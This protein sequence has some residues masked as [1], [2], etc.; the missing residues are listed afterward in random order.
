MLYAVRLGPP[1]VARAVVVEGPLDVLA[2]AAAAATTGLPMLSCSTAGVTVSEAQAQTVSTLTRRQVVLA[3][4]GDA[5]GRDGTIRWVELLQRR[6][7]HPVAV[8]DLPDGRDP[9]DVL[10]Q[11]GPTALLDLLARARPSAY[12]LAG[13]TRHA[14]RPVRPAHHVPS[15]DL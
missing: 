1:D 3:L 12:E 8:A 15:R 10:T 14:S 4:D 2:V 11:N 9:A 5:A 13:L 6:L 7:H